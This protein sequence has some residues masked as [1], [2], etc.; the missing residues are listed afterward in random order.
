MTE[1]LKIEGESL[2]L[3]STPER[4][5]IPWCCTSQVFIY[6]SSATFC[7][8][9]TVWVHMVL[10]K[11]T[12][13]K[14]DMGVGGEAEVN[15]SGQTNNKSWNSVHSFTIGNAENNTNKCHM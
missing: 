6:L 7:T 8:Y 11:D 12:M 13:V 9:S 1:W 10:H 3:L 14:A 5:F 2:F 15:S 4:T